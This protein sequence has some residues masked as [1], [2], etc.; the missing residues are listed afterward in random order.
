MR[1]NP[2]GTYLYLENGLGQEYGTEGELWHTLKRVKT[3]DMAAGL[4][5]ADWDL[6]GP[7][8]V[9]T[10]DLAYGVPGNP[11]G[12]LPRPGTDPYDR[13]DPEI[14]AANEYFLD[15]D[16]CA[17][18]F[19]PFTDGNSEA[20]SSI[21]PGCIVN[22]LVGEN[23]FGNGQVWESTDTYLFDR[24][25]KPGRADIYRK[26]VTGQFVG[27]EELLIK[28]ARGMDTGL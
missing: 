27:T 3:D 12:S 19:A 13:P 16:T 4:P 25:T 11:T 20:Q 28:D 9:Y 18:D 23:W 22:G 8:L 26:Y 15:A 10:A 21:W 14:I 5:I 2:S 1:F 7:E 24:N 17:I 6:S